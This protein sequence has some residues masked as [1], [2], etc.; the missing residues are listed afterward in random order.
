[1]L[2]PKGNREILPS[3]AKH[4]GQH[5]LT[6]DRIA[7]RIVDSVDPDLLD[8]LP[9]IE[10]GPGRM[11]LTR[12]LARRSPRLILVEKDARLIPLLEESFRELGDRVEIRRADALHESLVVQGSPYILL[13]NLPY[14]ISVPL[15][16]KII[17]A[18]PPPVQA[19]LMF[20]KE[21]ADRITAPPGGKDYGSL[22]VAAR[23]LSNPAHLFDIRPGS[24]HPPPKVHSTVLSFTPAETRLDPAIHGAIHLA[25]A[26]FSYRRKTLKNA[27]GLGLSA[28]I[29]EKVLLLLEHEPDRAGVRPETLSPGDWL[30]LARRLQEHN[31]EIFA[32]IEG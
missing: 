6:D 28:G 27:L 14:N 25:R 32:K 8:R 19:V 7:A 5:F 22:S 9:A 10:I 29:M 13:S 15:L 23:L 24:F 26:A 11:I 1:M 18:T 30:D 12:H 4:L 2:R 17:G 16:M 31:P 20:Q 3:P 21:V